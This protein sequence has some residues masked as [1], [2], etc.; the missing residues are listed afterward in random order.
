MLD[1]YRS[2]LEMLEQTETL[3]KNNNNG[4][5]QQHI[6]EDEANVTSSSSNNNNKTYTGSFQ[7]IIKH[8][9]DDYFLEDADEE[10]A[11][12]MAQRWVAF[13]RSGD[14]NY[15]DS[16]VKWMPWRYIP[17]EETDDDGRNFESY[18]PWD[19]HVEDDEVFDM[20]SD[21]EDEFR[22]EDDGYGP[23]WSEDAIGRAYRRRALLALNMEV[24]EEDDLR[25][26][27]KKLKSNDRDPDNPF[28]ALKFLAKLGIPWRDSM[29]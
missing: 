23:S 18:L 14:P 13:A 6:A 8:F 28:F 3:D 10:I 27:L 22:G 26:E 29:A 19:E 20:M 15:G 25:T 5:T 1:A 2:S 16:K 7:R 17:K 4:T 21:A 11:S 24:V 12:D 9:F